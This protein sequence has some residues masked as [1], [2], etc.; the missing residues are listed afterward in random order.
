MYVR[1]F[2]KALLRT[3][4]ANRRDGHI[5]EIYHFVNLLLHSFLIFQQHGIILCENNSC[6][7]PD[8]SIHF[9]NIFNE[10]RDVVYII[11]IMVHI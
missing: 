6:L 11:I 1:L 4:T 9:L 5:L 10:K 2:D 7:H 3:S 8:L